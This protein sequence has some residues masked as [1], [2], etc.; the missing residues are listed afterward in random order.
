MGNMDDSMAQGYRT[1]FP[2]RQANERPLWQSA[3]SMLAAVLLA[4]LFLSSGLW[5]LIDPISWS[6]RL[7]QALVPRQLAL[8]GALAVGLAETLGAILVL[9]PRWRRWGAWICGGLLL[10][11][12]AYFAVNYRTLQGGDC[13]CFPWLKRVV[14][15]GFFAGDAGMLLLAVLAGLWSKPSHAWK[16]AAAVLVSI[17]IFAGVLYGYQAMRGGGVVAPPSVTVDGKPFPLR[18][19]KVF[20]FFFDPE[21]AHCYAA[22]Q[23]FSTYHWKN[24]IQLVSVVAVPVVHPQWGEMFLRR[25]GFSS[26]LT[27]DK[28]VLRG[29]FKFTD[30]PYAVTLDNGRLVK[31]LPFFDETEPRKTLKAMGWIE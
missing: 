24:G 20:V 8:A 29:A 5:K 1:A 13:S 2:A 10:V 30:P 4:L 7:V 27:L 12:M 19:G 14:G 22:A 16:Q 31:A 23:D 3:V 6:E 15:P 17:A 26:K 18:E 28:E 11:F 21:C 9:V 25:T